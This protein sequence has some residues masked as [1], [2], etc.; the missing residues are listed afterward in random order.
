LSLARSRVVTATCEIDPTLADT[1]IV[2]DGIVESADAGR[3]RISI[4]AQQVTL[5]LAYR[6]FGWKSQKKLTVF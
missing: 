5:L 2:P 4:I 1:G 3:S 6:Q